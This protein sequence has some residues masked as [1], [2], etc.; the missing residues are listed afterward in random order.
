MKQAQTINEWY[1]I[2]AEALEGGDIEQA[3]NLFDAEATFVVQPGQLATDADSIRAGLEGF[4]AMKTT[5]KF[6]RVGMIVASN[7][8]FARAKWTLSGTGPNAATVAAATDTR[9]DRK[10]PTADHFHHVL[11]ELPGLVR[12]VGEEVTVRREFRRELVSRGSDS[13]E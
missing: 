4:I 12:V 10:R 13:T 5:V 9:R 8:G 2:F 6:E 1:D 11:F 7:I 3:V